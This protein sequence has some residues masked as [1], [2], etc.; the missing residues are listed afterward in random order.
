MSMLRRLIVFVRSIG[1]ATSGVSAPTKLTLVILAILAY[2]QLTY[3]QTPHSVVLTWNAPVDSPI[4][5]AH[6]RVFRSRGGRPWQVIAN[7]PQT[8]FTDTQVVSGQHLRYQV[9]SVAA[10]GT[11][12][13]RTPPTPTVV[14]P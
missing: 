11:Q 12:S 7:P 1:L 3:G 6:Y 8:T 10:D 4:P 2:G 14:I 5:V 13:V 9:S